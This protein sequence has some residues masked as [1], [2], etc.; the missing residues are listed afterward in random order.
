LPESA[1]ARAQNLPFPLIALARFSDFDV[2]ICDGN[3]SIA[4]KLDKLRV[5]PDEPPGLDAVLSALALWIAEIHPHDYW[6]V[7]FGGRR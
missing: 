7:L 6:S 2:V 5:G 3:K 1:R 4:N